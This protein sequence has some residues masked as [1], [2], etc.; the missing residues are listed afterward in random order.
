MGERQPPKQATEVQHNGVSMV[1]P[2]YLLHGTLPSF[3][4][5][6]QVSNTVSDGIDPVTHLGL[7]CNREFSERPSAVLAGQGVLHGHQS[8]QPQA[9][10]GETGP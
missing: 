7:E 4:Y 8:S 1:F 9:D 2:K 3:S 6:K 10:G 5:T